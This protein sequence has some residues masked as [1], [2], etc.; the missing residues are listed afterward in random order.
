MPTGPPVVASVVKQSPGPWPRFRGL[1]AAVKPGHRCDPR[2]DSGNLSRINE[3]VHPALIV[4][5]GRRNTFQ[6]YHIIN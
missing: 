1:L 3:F 5:I 2:G 4:F 6:T